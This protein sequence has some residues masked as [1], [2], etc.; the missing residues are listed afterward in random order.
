MGA[1]G[2]RARWDRML[3]RCLH[4]ERCRSTRRQVA[5]VRVASAGGSASAG[6]MLLRLDHAVQVSNRTFNVVVFVLRRPTFRCQKPAPV[7][8]FEVSIGKL[9]RSF[10]VVRFLVI[11]AQVP[12]RIF[13]KPVQTNEFIFVFRGRLVFAPIVSLVVDVLSFKDECLGVFKCFSVQLY[14]HNLSLSIWLFEE[15]VRPS[16]HG[17]SERRIQ[18]NVDLI[19]GGRDAARRADRYRPPPVTV[20]RV[21]SK[22]TC[23]P[24][25][26]SSMELRKQNVPRLGTC[27]A[28]PAIERPPAEPDLNAR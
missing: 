18:E 8:V 24:L 2:A 21:P 6:W 16:R 10:G 15:I 26:G 1:S 25:T 11:D 20:P 23:K 27:K 3:S 14:C 22:I 17:R 19:V 9:V 28:L 5:A 12:L 7:D 13:A 4:L